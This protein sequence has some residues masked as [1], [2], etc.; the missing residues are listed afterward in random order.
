[1][2][3]FEINNFDNNDD[4]Q[5]LRRSSEPR[6]SLNSSLKRSNSDNE[7]SA[8]MMEDEDEVPQQLKPI[9]KSKPPSQI[10]KPIWSN[11]LSVSMVNMNTQSPLLKANSSTKTR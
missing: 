11:K 1:M 4:L 10:P 6:N 3:A 9:I 8:I 7:I 2:S 5:P